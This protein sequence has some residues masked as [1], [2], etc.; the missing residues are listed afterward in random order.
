MST[1]GF[2]D[3]VLQLYRLA[4]EVDYDDFQ[5][6]ALKAVQPL[7]PFDGAMWLLVGFVGDTAYPLYRHVMG[8][9]ESFMDYVATIGDQDPL[10]RRTL[11]RPGITAAASVQLD[12]VP[13][14]FRKW[15]ERYNIAHAISTLSE[16]DKLSQLRLVVSL[17]RSDALPPF[18][19]AERRRKQSLMPHLIESHRQNRRAVI[20][21]AL[22]RAWEAQHSTALV[23]GRGVL[24]HAEQAF[25][26]LLA[27]NWPEWRGAKAPEPLV[28]RLVQRDS[29]ELSTATD[30][31]RC[32]PLGDLYLLVGTESNV[33]REL[34]TRERQVATRFSEGFTYRE[35][36]DQLSLSPATVRN[37]I[38]RIYQKLDVG[39]KTELRDKLAS[40]A[41]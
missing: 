22:L 41:P 20:H 40:G 30:L 10:R 8:R 29:W 17:W 19:E 2:N 33:L 38:A 27:R 26:Q 31:I 14:D 7:I 4:R 32:A 9:P 28:E 13:E 36:A 1:T 39:N 23:D 35:I 12:P 21:Q 16:F 15:L 24:Y 18:T 37:Y 25:I 3:C 11:E 5:S 34:T 6:Q